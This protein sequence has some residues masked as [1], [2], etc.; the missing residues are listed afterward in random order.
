MQRAFFIE[1]F[2]RCN[3]FYTIDK[4]LKKIITHGYLYLLFFPGIGNAV[5]AIKIC[6]AKYIT[7]T[8][9]EVER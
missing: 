7:R 6:K 2:K 9:T 8:Y 5:Y 3:R 1:L 4:K